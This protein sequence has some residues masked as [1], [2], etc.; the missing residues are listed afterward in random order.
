MTRAGLMPPWMP[1]PDSA[2]LVG[3]DH[4]R[5]TRS[6]LQTL[7]A[8]AAAGAPAGNP[9]DRHAKPSTGAGLG[10]PGTT[11]TL[12]APDARTCR[13]RPAA[14]STTTTASCSTQLAATSSSPA[15]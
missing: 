7:A 4:R 8:W 2:P 11:I 6:Q 5:L 14:A 12:A 3:R 10:G 15:R 1:G 13:T 9:A